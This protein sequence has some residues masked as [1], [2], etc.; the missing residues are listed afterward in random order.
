M[1]QESGQAATS[2]RKFDQGLPSTPVDVST[3]VDDWIN[4]SATPQGWHSL[5]TSYVDGVPMI[6]TRLADGS[7]AEFSGVTLYGGIGS[8]QLT[9][10]SARCT[11][12]G[13]R[14]LLQG[15]L[16][17]GLLVL[18]TF[19]IPADGEIGFFSREFFARSR[20]STPITRAAASDPGALFEQFTQSES[21]SMEAML[22]RWNIAD[23]RSRGLLE[24]TV[25]E[26][27]SGFTAGALGSPVSNGDAPVDWGVTDI[28]IFACL[29]DAGH[30]SLSALA[31]W[32]F[33]FLSTHL[34]LRVPSGTL[35]MAG[36]NEFRDGRM[37]YA[38]REFFYRLP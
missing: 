20:L 36:F 19:K 35:A 23:F 9:A 10:F 25:E 28:G 7:V 14:I 11:D 13:S 26:V 24:I 30:P 34:Q 6:H 3:F 2:F 37:N 33:G 8:P 1:T 18:A 38:T 17:L 32:D 22:G 31:S 29:D 5:R 4:T 21:V 16:N 15:N 27:G 12:A